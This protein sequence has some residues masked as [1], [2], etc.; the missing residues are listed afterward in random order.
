MRTPLI[1]GRTFT[2]ADNTTDRRLIM[3]DDFLAKKAFPGESA[4]GKRILIRL[5]TPEPEWMEIIGVVG[6]VRQTSLSIP[7]RE[8]IYF[9]DGYGGPGAVNSWALRVGGNPV[10]FASQVRAAIKDVSPRLL[11]SDLQ[12]V[13]RLVTQAQAQTSFSLLLIGVFAPKE[14]SRAPGSQHRPILHACCSSRFPEWRPW[15]RLNRYML[16]VRPTEAKPQNNRVRPAC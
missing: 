5:K 11:V 10:E 4:V 3:I 6:H 2:D 16:I 14:A 7:G 9:T 15:T 12:P 13:D 8:Q 1:A